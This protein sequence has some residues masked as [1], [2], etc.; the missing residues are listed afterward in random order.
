[1][2]DVP[3]REYFD[4]QLDELRRTGDDIV[5]AVEKLGL[6]IG[7]VSLRE[8]IEALFE[9]HRRGMVTAE[10]EREKAAQIVADHQAATIATVERVLREHVSQQ[11]HQINAAIGSL[12]REMT[13]IHD[14]SE[15]AIEKAELANDK[16]FEAF[17][18]FREQLAEERNTFQRVDVAEAQLAELRRAIAELVEKV[19][20]VV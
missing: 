9:E 18:A 15:R 14:A 7:S 5:K 13:L 19:S 10:Q 8:Y 16:R 11:V 4:L 17:N 12:Q 1:M 3:Y 2:T 6:S 20:K